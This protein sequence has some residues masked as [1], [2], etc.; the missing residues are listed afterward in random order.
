LSSAHSAYE[1][2]DINPFK[3]IGFSVVGVVFLV[4]ILIILRDYFIAEIEAIYY[5]TTLKPVS[6]EL[7]DIRARE[8]DVLN[9]YKL[10]DPQKDIYQIPIE[11]AMQLIAEE[12]FARRLQ[13]LKQ[14]R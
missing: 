8:I 9:N 7:R 11:R 1:K 13:V 12:S 10:L 3:V 6:A 2:K 14:T 5:E 4:V